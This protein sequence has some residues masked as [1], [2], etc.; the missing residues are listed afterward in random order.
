[1]REKELCKILNVDK[2]LIKCI[3]VN[4]DGDCFY[5]CIS[6]IVNVSIQELRNIVASMFTDNIYE[7]YKATCQFSDELIWIRRCKNVNEAK[8]LLSIPKLV[9]ADEFALS[10]IIQHF[11]L[12]LYIINEGNG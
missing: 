1:M 8:E 9:W 6:Q 3:V 7:D 10:V 2:D 12:T 11:D 4:A 5:H